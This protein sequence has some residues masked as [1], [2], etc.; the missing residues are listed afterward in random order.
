LAWKQASRKGKK[1]SIAMMMMMMMVMRKRR[2][3][4]VLGDYVLC[5]KSIV[6]KEESLQ[7]RRWVDY[8]LV[9]CKL[10]NGENMMN[11]IIHT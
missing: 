1:G 9:L 7:K 8:S 3:V 5:E 10:S 6:E 11:I 4:C 2:K